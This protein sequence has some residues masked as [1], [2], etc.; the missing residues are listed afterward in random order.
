MTGVSHV[1]DLGFKENINSI[2][3]NDYNNNADRNDMDNN[4]DK[5]I[6][7]FKSIKCHAF[8]ESQAQADRNDHNP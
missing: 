7:F 3:D 5:K 1:T 4:N 6:F 2:K 8:S